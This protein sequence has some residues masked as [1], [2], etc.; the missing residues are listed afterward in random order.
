MSTLTAREILDLEYHGSD[1]FMTPHIIR[2]G[3][4]GKKRAYEL[5]SGEG[6]EPGSTIYGVSV[7]DVLDD[8]TTDR[9]TDISDCFQSLTEAEIMIMGLEDLE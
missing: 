1:N 5:A 8:G 9:R 6:F 2:T 7:V 4:A 3:K